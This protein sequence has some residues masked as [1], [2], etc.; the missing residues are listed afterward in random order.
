MGL[1]DDFSGYLSTPQG[2]ALLSAAGSYAAGAKRGTPWNNAG[3]GLLGGV[4][5]YSNAQDQQAQMAQAEQMKKVRQ[6]QMDQAAQTQQDALNKKAQIEA[7]AQSLPV[8]EQKRFRLNP[9]SYIKDATESK[10]VSPGSV[11][12]R[13]GVQTF[14]APEA[15]KLPWYVKKGDNGLYIDPA[16]SELEKAKA[17]YGRPPAQPMAPVAYVDPSGQTVWGT[18]TDAR[19]KPAANYNP[20][21][22]GQVAGAKA[23][24]KIQA[25]N[26]QEVNTA[27]SS[28]PQIESTVKDLKGMAK[29]ATYTYAGQVRDAVA[30]Q[31]GYATE[32]AV[33][34]E[35]YT[36]TVKDVLFPQLRATFGAQFTV[37][38]GEALIATLGDPDKTP[39][40][41]NAAL[42]A[43]VD[44]KKKTL[45]SL[46]RKAGMGGQKP[47]SIHDQADAI[48]RGK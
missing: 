25:D 3:R 20:M 23:G 10:V 16:Y 40:E 38:E 45:E 31:L 30:R 17:A 37:K 7:F 12:L 26:N 19:G 28:I 4:M 46:K 13:G 8:D 39:E 29:D 21:V 41:K 9:D 24:G 36:N 18:I 33:A 22:Q 42:D 32:G 5:G 6:L 1:L 48:L 43:F 27:Q 14:A 35:K 15:E 2:Q 11:V 44:Q 47:S 34:R